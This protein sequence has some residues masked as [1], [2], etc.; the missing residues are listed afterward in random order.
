MNRYFD[1]TI[2]NFTISI[3]YQGS[4]HLSRIV[5]QP[6]FDRLGVVLQM[7]VH[8]GCDV[9]PRSLGGRRFH[10]PGV[11]GCWGGLMGSAGCGQRLQSG[12]HSGEQPGPGCLRGQVQAAGSTVLG[13][14]PGDAEQV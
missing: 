13:Q 11:L 5:R 12:D 10:G 6:V 9:C 14:A 1:F 3:A 2:A 8:A 4:L 7:I